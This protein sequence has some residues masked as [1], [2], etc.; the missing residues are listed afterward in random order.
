MTDHDTGWMEDLTED[1]KCAKCGD[2]MPR[3]FHHFAHYIGGRVD[4]YH[5]NCA[6]DKKIKARCLERRA[7]RCR[8]ME[9]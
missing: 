6:R 9:D 8:P 2:L 4:R 5:V 7:P 1:T 3:F